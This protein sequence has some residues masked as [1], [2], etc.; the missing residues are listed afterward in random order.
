MARI[1]LIHGAWH[2]GWCWDAVADRLRAMGHAV[3]APDMPGGAAT[4]ADCGAVV[5]EGPALLVGHSLGGMVIEALAARATAL[6]HLCSY[7][8]RPGDSLAALDRMG[9][10]P[11]NGPRNWPRDDQ[12]RL[13]MPPEA[14]REMLY[15]DCPPP[16]VARALARLRPQPTGPMR[17]PLPGPRIALPRHYI[18]CRN[19]RAIAPG[20]Q[21]AMLARAP[22]DQVHA[23]DWGHSP[24]LS[25]PGELARLLDRI[26][27]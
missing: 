12:G 20:L 19:D 15:H 13:L 6:V 5:G 11:R 8:P 1:V 26:A 24:F 14:A 9:G 4:L 7:L 27:R 23:R 25:A 18:L 22:V 2:G 3:D 21:Q 10:M 16:E 17:E